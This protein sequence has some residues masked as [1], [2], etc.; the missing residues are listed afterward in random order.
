MRKRGG[1]LSNKC[2]LC[3]QSLKYHN[4]NVKLYVCSILVFY[5]M[6]GI[7]QNAKENKV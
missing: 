3:A 2:N 5:H 4:M 7:L 6:L 1:A